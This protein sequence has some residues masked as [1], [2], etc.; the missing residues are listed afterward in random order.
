M[1]HKARQAGLDLSVRVL[2]TGLAGL[3][4]TVLLYQGDRGRPKAR[5]MLTET[6]PAQD[7]LTQVFQ[8]DRCA[9]RR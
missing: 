9:P 1:R 4:E 2:P 7:T 5:R 8:L 6:S 3:E